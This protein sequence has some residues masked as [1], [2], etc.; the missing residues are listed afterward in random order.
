MLIQA[1]KKKIA[2]SSVPVRINPVTRESRLFRSIPHFI[3][4]SLSTML[5]IYSMYSPLRVFTLLS[6][7]F[8]VIGVAPVTRFLYFVAIGEVQGHVQSLVLGGAF[9]VMGTITFLIGLV[10][11]LLSFNRQLLEIC[12]EKI[13]VLEA[14]AR[15]RD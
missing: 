7:V 1:G 8:F 3:E 4:R 12:L 5:R 6:F 2:V 11:D 9:L 10:A 14:G 13:R 15:N